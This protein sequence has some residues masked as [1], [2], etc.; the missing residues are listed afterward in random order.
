MRGE[1]VA[2]LKGI[3]PRMLRPRTGESSRVEPVAGAPLTAS[4]GGR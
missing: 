4:T 2:G 1:I 3:V